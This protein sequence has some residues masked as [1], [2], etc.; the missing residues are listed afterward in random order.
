MPY[1]FTVTYILSTNPQER[2]EIKKELGL[3][4]PLGKR[5]LNWVFKLVQGDLGTDFNGNNVSDSI[6]D[7]IPPTL[8]VFG[9]GSIAAFFLGK[10]LGTFAAWQRESWL[11]KVATGGAV[12][13]NTIF[14]P[15]FSVAVIP[16][17]CIPLY[18]LAGGLRFKKSRGLYISSLN[19]EIWGSQRT[20]EGFASF[21]DPKTVMAYMFISICILGIGLILLNRSVQKLFRRK[22]PGWVNLILLIGIWVASWF[23]FDYGTKAF[24]VL[25]FAIKPLLAYILLTFGDTVIIMKSSMQDTLHEDY[26]TTAK[27]KGLSEKTVREKHASRNAILPA[28]S[29]YVINLPYLFTGAVI[30][31]SATGWTGLGMG[32]FGALYHMNIP[33]FLGGLVVVG[34]ITLVA[35]IALEIAQ[36]VIDPRI[37]ELYHQ[38]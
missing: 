38:S 23:M 14:P 12:T 27:A 3:H 5:Y 6:K 18:A 11:A 34:L 15:W 33:L 19:A 35:Q 20:P 13:L 25:L 7:L 36:A 32:L 8:L 9:L 31:E 22:I 28:I 17:L 37:L 16:Y 10:W 21:V 30:I 1:D 26:I 24:D 4:L 2:E 29:R